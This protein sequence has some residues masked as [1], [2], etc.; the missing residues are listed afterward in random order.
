M[1]EKFINLIIILI[2]V[3]IPALGTFLF[4]VNVDWGA[5]SSTLEKVATLGIGISIVGSLLLWLLLKLC[6]KIKFLNNFIEK[7]PVKKIIEYLSKIF[8]FI[9]VSIVLYGLLLFLLV[10]NRSFG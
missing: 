10:G 8:I 3:L 7:P 2:L 4:I 5:P 1:K 6:E 9:W